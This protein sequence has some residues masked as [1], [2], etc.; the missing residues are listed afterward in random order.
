MKLDRSTYEAW[1]LDRM[2][3]NL[4]AEQDAELRAFLLL[5]P[6]LDDDL[7][8][9]LSVEDGPVP[10]PDKDLLKRQVPPTG[11][12]DPARLEDFLIAGGEGDLDPAQRRAL[13]AYLLQ[14]PDAGR[15][16]RLIAAARIQPTS[17]VFP[18]RET[19]QRT[20]P[21]SGQPDK[22]RLT[23]FLIAAEE[24]DLDA[25]QA[26]ALDLLV[27][28]DAG[29]QRERTLVQASRIR[30]GTEVFQA[31]RL[32]YKERVT[33]VIPLWQRL[34]LAASLLI[35]VTVAVRYAVKPS[36]GG[37]SV[38]VTTPTLPAAP[39]APS[40][41]VEVEG[42]GLDDTRDAPMADRATPAPMNTQ[43]KAAIGVTNSGTSGTTRRAD[44]PT[45]APAAA[46]GGD[47]GTRPTPSVVAPTEPTV[48]EPTPE[49]LPLA[50]N[51]E[52]Q[53]APAQAGAGSTNTLGT[54]LA[55]TVR[56]EVL[57]TSERPQDLDRRDAVAMVD[58]G[59]SALTNGEGGMEVQR[60]KERK[61]VFLRLGGNFEIMASSGR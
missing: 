42:P 24:G 30:P 26:A 45:E 55:N 3:G 61:R 40:K 8:G 37:P 58:K 49:V 23:D 46:R 7:P 17:T 27:L 53:G 35:A 11:R 1:L 34:A 36:G 60:V 10:F 28:G 47:P 33:R 6:D 51:D 12:F 14:H 38:A 16:E 22:H 21:P 56:H 41:A 57:G 15:T 43:G 59:L 50:R 20:I 31:K 29:A 9:S 2:E 52:Q 54:L 32:L 44:P 39:A 4:S 48:P 19:L 25:D 13:E 5:N 18:D